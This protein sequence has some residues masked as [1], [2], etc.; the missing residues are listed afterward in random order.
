MNVKILDSWLREHLITKASAKQIAETLSLSS[1]SIERVEKVGTD[2][3]YDIEVTTNR[4]DLASVVGLAREAAAVL[5]QYDHSAE[6]VAPK[7]QTPK[8]ESK[9]KITIEN[10][11]TL[12]NRIL[13]VV[14]EVNVKKSPEKISKRLEKATI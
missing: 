1:V 7:L 14:M 9:V 11:K 4:P 8:H 3:L 12:V 2:Y 5:P 13:A 6:F 10:D